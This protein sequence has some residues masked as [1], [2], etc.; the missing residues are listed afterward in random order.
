MVGIATA[1]VYHHRIDHGWF[2]EWAGDCACIIW[3]N[4]SN[5]IVYSYLLSKRHQID[6]ERCIYKPFRSLGPRDLYHSDHHF[7]PCGQHDRSM[8]DG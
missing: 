6:K 8:V 4:I 5:N 1:M 3:Y 2:M 7:H